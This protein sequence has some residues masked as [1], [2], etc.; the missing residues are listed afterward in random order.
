L[1]GREAIAASCSSD[2]FLSGAVGMRA[3]I[4]ILLSAAALVSCTPE[5]NEVTG[6][7]NNCAKKMFTPYNP[8]DMKQCVAACIACENGVI[9]TCSTS[10]TL[11]GA[12]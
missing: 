5:S 2:G 10:C 8:K 11:K 9:T 7:I 1:R 4:F 6:S 3:I 12:R